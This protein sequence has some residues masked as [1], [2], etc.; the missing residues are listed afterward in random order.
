M[1]GSRRLRVGN[2]QRAAKRV[3]DIGLALIALLALAPIMAV[4]ATLIVIE[5]PGPVFYRAERV[6]YRGR[7]LRMLKFRKMFRDAAG[8]AVTVAGDSRLTHVGRVLVRTRLDELPQLWHVLRGDMSLVG[9]RPEDP[10]FVACYPREYSEILQVRPGITGCTQIVFANEAAL[11]RQSDPHKHYVEV[12]LPQ[13]I[14]LDRMYAARPT[15]TCDGRV[16]WLTFLLVV[17]R[18]QVAADQ[19]RDATARPQV[20]STEL[21]GAA[22]VARR[23][24]RE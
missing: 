17:A 4:I 13:K 8:P 5:T 3:I 7:R 9:P 11:L 22:A 19:A 14:A 21:S 1:G 6:G 23:A 18:R 16:L 12:I 15:L 2:G 10:C 24:M 20:T